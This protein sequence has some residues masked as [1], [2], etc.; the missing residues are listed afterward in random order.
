MTFDAVKVL[1]K[2]RV[3][4]DSAGVAPRVLTTAYQ[5]LSGRAPK[6]PNPCCTRSSWSQ[7]RARQFAEAY[8]ATAQT[9]CL[10]AT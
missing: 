9:D 5:Y 6:Q 3:R 8:E 10:P 1:G 7:G 4:T 2:V